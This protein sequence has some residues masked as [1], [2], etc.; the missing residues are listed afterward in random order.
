VAGFWKISPNTIESKR[1]R[2]YSSEKA[3]V[4]IILS[5]KRICQVSIYGVL[6]T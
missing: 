2:L 3:F 5:V 6:N 4:K 1:M